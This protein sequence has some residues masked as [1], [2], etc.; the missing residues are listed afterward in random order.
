MFFLSECS[1][2]HLMNLKVFLINKIMWHRW[3]EFKLAASYLHVNLV[4]C[5]RQ[6]PDCTMFVF[7]A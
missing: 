2:K 4:F 3:Q 7:N 6:T 5:E 1:Q